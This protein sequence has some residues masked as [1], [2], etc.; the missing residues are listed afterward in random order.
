MSFT[1]VVEFEIDGGWVNVT[2]LDDSTY[3]M[4]P[5]TITRGRA[6]QGERMSPMQ[7]SFRMRDDN[8]VIDGENPA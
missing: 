2:E 7:I 1:L 5:V 6:R 8:C 3:V 4:A